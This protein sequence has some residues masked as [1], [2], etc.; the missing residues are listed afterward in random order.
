MEPL[1]ITV[2][3]AAQLGGPC[4]SALYEDIRAGRLRAVKRGRSTR[5]LLEDFKA[6]LASFPPLQSPR[7]G[8][9]EEIA[10]VEKSA[11]QIKVASGK[12]QIS[13]T[14]DASKDQGA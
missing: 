8:S 5:I 2:S 12:S 1:A 6:Y 10:T 9:G 14:D 3:Q 7:Q 4:R 13:G 11:K